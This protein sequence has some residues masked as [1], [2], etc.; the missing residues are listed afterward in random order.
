MLGLSQVLCIPHTTTFSTTSMFLRFPTRS[1]S[2]SLSDCVSVCVYTLARKP[3]TL[4]LSIVVKT[5]VDSTTYSAP[6]LPQGIAVG[7]FLQ[8]FGR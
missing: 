6:L 4:A 8:Q 7:S 5:P 2:F 1:L 3:L